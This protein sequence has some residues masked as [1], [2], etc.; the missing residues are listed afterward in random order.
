MFLN[1]KD[2]WAQPLAKSSRLFTGRDDRSL[3]GLRLPIGSEV[4]MEKPLAPGIFR[5]APECFARLEATFRTFRNFQHHGTPAL[6]AAT[7]SFQRVARMLQKKLFELFFE[8]FLDTFFERVLDPGAVGAA[9][10]QGHPLPH[11]LRVRIPLAECEH[12]L[13]AVLDHKIEPPFV[14]GAE[15]VIP[16]LARHVPRRIEL[17]PSAGSGNILGFL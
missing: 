17:A 13:A 7:W 9:P 12:L 15:L 2:G 3:E 5:A 10:G 8:M 16:V 4:V 6:G 1:K 14:R 11:T